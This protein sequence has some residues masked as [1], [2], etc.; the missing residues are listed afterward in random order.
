MVCG[1]DFCNDIPTGV[2]R[3]IM[4]KADLDDSG[5]LE[6]PEF[7]AMVGQSLFQIFLKI[8][9]YWKSNLF[10]HFRDNKKYILIL[11]KIV[12]G[13]SQSFLLLF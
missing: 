3:T 4:R 10:F 11:Q 5:Y 6:Y 13:S 1:P 7:I 9:T 2:I 12:N 8:A